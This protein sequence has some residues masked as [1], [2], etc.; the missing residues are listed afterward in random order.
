MRDFS[1]RQSQLFLMVATFLVGYQA[2]ELQQI[3]DDDAREATAAL[4]STFETASRGVIYDYR[5]S[6]LPAERL[7]AGLKPL[8]LEAGKNGGSVVE[9]DT[10]V[11]LRRV[12]EAV[13]EA[14]P[15]DPDNRRAFL[16]LLGRV[17]RKPDRESAAERS[18]HE[19]PRL[20]VP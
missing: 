6:S 1:E 9:R 5:P 17:I 15:H 19:A 20:I 10:A 2:T 8:L 4:A 3:I 12:S 7:A 16:S 14:R 18:E 13:G 11:V